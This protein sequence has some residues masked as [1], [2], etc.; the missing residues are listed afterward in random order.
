[1]QPKAVAF[2]T[3]A[4]LMHRACMR[5]VRL[6]ERHGVQLR[7]TYVRVG[8]LALMKHQ[9]YVHAKQYKRARGVI[10]APS[11]LSWC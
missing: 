8:K 3:D 4:K 1:V 2:P 5:L 11:D 9:R 10:T 6:T 7:Q